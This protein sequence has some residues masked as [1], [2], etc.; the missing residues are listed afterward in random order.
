MRVKCAKENLTNAWKQPSEVILKYSLQP[1]PFDIL[2]YIYF[3]VLFQT[4][5]LIKSESYG[6]STAPRQ[7]KITSTNSNLDF[8]EAVSVFQDFNMLEVMKK[9]LLKRTRLNNAGLAKSETMDTAEDLAI[10]VKLQ[11]DH[12]GKLELLHKICE[13]FPALAEEAS[14]P[15]LIKENLPFLSCQF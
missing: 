2:F 6:N 1:A 9:A 3:L 11:N 13:E 7:K 5:G 14:F 15:P 12:E 8:S 10:F 4:D